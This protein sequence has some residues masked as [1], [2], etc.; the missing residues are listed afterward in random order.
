MVSSRF[1]IQI[2]KY[3]PLVARNSNGTFTRETGAEDEAARPTASMV[4]SFIVMGLPDRITE[5]DPGESLTRLGWAPAKT[6]RWCQQSLR[7]D[8]R[9]THGSAISGRLCERW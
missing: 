4:V 9:S 5:G 3:S 6:C 8:S 2:R 1:T 7:R